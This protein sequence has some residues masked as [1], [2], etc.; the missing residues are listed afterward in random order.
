MGMI[1]CWVRLS[2]MFLAIAVATIHAREAVHSGENGLATHGCSEALLNAFVDA[3]LADLG[4]N[5]SI[6]SSITLLQTALVGQDTSEEPAAKVNIGLDVKTTDVAALDLLQQ[7]L[8]TIDATFSEHPLVNTSHNNHNLTAA[9]VD[10]VEQDL[11]TNNATFSERPSAE[12]NVTNV[13]AGNLSSGA[14]TSAIR[15]WL[16]QARYPTLQQSIPHRKS[17]LTAQI[18]FAEIMLLLVGVCLLILWSLRPKREVEI[19]REAIL[20]QVYKEAE[21]VY[22]LQ[23]QQDTDHIK[24]GLHNSHSVGEPSHALNSIV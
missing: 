17:S 3:E 9:A 21:R 5:S 13:T 15:A 18:Q 16:E 2:T 8:T 24:K 6:R 23:K 4:N 1:A 12:L 22:D 10:P 14:S 19:D 7:N 20:R 11:A